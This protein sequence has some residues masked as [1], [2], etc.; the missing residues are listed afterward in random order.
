MEPGKNWRYQNTAFF[1]FVNGDQPNQPI[2][3]ETTSRTAAPP[4]HCRKP[5]HHWLDFIGQL[6]SNPPEITRAT[7]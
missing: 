1:H 4:G 6:F 7:S 2:Q 5:A 3:P